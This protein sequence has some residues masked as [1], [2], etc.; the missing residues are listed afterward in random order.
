MPFN[1]ERQF[2]ARLFS[3]ESLIGERNLLAIYGNGRAN[4]MPGSGFLFREPTNSALDISM[5]SGSSSC[6]VM[7]VLSSVGIRNLSIVENTPD[8]LKISM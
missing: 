2:A 1:L 8:L 3:C 7:T 5:G 4:K 6:P